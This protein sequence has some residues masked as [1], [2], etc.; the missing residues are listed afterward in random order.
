MQSLTFAMLLA[1]AAAALSWWLI[2]LYARRMQASH[3]LSAPN[4]RSMHKVP[5]PVGA[6][7]AIVVAVLVLWPL[8]Q[9]GLGKQHTLLLAC[10]AGLGLVSWIDDYRALS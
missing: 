8:G 3:R 6:G 4:E 2:G 5:V 10:F 7:F 9:G 1:L